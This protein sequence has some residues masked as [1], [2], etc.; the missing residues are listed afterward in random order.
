MMKMAQFEPSVLRWGI[1]DG[2]CSIGGDGVDVDILEWFT[3]R[4]FGGN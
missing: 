4:L 3:K 1:L 2:S